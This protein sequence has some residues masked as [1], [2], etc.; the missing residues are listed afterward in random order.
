MPGMS[1]SNRISL[2]GLLFAV[3]LAAGFGG[4][5]TND[6]DMGPGEYDRASML[7]NVANN[8][9]LPN[10]QALRTEVNALATAADAFV[11]ARDSAGLVALR[12]AW[13][14]T[15]L[16]WQHCSAFEFGPAQTVSLRAQVN[17]F[18]T[19]TA[20]IHANINAGS[21]DLE[22]AANLD[23]KGFP[24][25]D[26]LLHGSGNTISEIVNLF[27][28]QN[29]A[30]YLTAVVTD[31]HTKITQVV[32]GWEASGG[33]YLSDFVASTGTDVGSSTSLLVNQLNMDWELMK[34]AKIGIPLGKKSLGQI[35]PEKVEALYS[36]R[37]MELA[38]EN[39]LA[40]RDLFTGT[41]RSGLD[42]IGLD[43]N[44]EQL[45]AQYNGESLSTAIKNG[46]AEVITAANAV[47]DPL[48]ATIQTN[49]A[50]VETLH[51]KIQMQVVLLKADMTSA[52]AILITYQ[53]ADGD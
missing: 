16:E 12:D 46:F 43:D 33:N 3:L 31:L 4:C 36:G 42:G 44:L 53:D 24:A 9:I 5:K 2:P 25:L 39:I 32:T 20:T 7:S 49:P 8:I 37:S 22:S 28:Q 1:F 30:D 41:D 6:D 38:Y 26:F 10:Y 21:Y 29:Y 15:A 18:P 27:S 47:P 17:T 48:S 45:D 19:D 11:T 13:L 14:A 52:L 50:P 23:A 51:Q 34:N 40:I 35:L